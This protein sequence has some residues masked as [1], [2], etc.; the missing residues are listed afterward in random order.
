[1]IKKFKFLFFIMVL[2]FIFDLCLADVIGN[3]TD[4]NYTYISNL[5]TD[6]IYTSTMVF[7]SEY[8]IQMDTQNATGLT[9]RSEC[10]TSNLWDNDIIFSINGNIGIDNIY[11]LNESSLTAN[12]L[13]VNSNS[14]IE[15]FADNLN[16]S[17]GIINNGA[18]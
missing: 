4:E 17:G 14:F 10:E 6:V 18:F 8:L 11:L 15:T 9:V 5:S 13:T 2:M 1:M 3:K 16:I 12:A 7:T